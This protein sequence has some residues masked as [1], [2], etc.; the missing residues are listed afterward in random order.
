MQGHPE[1]RAESPRRQTHMGEWLREASACLSDIDVASVL[2]LLVAIVLQPC[3]SL[4][5][6]LSLCVTKGRDG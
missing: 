5:M 1:T 2:V 3:C 6:V 4:A